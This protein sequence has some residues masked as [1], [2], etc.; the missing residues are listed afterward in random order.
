MTIKSSYRNSTFCRAHSVTTNRC[1][2]KKLNKNYNADYS[3]LYN[4][5]KNKYNS[6]STLKKCLMYVETY[7]YIYIESKITFIVSKIDLRTSVCYL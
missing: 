4:Y 5:Y 6:I 3:V 7:L 1:N 2:L